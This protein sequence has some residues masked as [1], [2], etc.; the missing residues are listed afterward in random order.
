MLDLIY[1]SVIIFIA[2]IPT[3]A[4]AYGFS[5]TATPLLLIRY[6]N[7]QI[8]PIL[9]FIEMFQNLTNVIL[10]FKNYSIRSLVFT[11]FGTP[12]VLI[13]SIV[14]AY[15]LKISANETLFKVIVYSILIPLILLQ[16]AGFRKE[17]G[18]EKW[19]KIG[20]L[21]TFPVGVLYGVTTI[22][23]PP[24]A[25]IINNQGLTK[26]EFKFAIAVLRTVESVSTFGAYLTLGIFNPQV[27]YYAT[28][29]SP[30]VI[31]GM[32]IGIFMGNVIKHKEDFRRLV[33]SF[34]SWISGYGL[35]FNLAKVVDYGVWYWPMTAIIAID[36]Y[37]LLRYIKGRRRLLK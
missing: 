32:L 4:F 26:Q 2:S 18:L 3:G 8:S 36:L 34:D 21:V 35:S 7:K 15:I 14:G 16:A 23:G 30:A 25:L 29:T 20:Y 1:L 19:K 27:I 33:M 11:I 10:N 13:G 24:L 31:A 22:S 17:I 9:N 6:T 5:S 37:L 28:V 12:G